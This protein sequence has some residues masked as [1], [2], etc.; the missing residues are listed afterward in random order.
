MERT[1]PG[2]LVVGVDAS[3]AGDAALHHAFTEAVLRGASLRVVV[4]CPPA[5]PRASGDGPLPVPD[6]GT[7]RRALAALVRRHVDDVRPLVP[8]AADVEVDVRAVTGGP[9]EVL[10]GA[11]RDADLLVVGHRGRGARCGEPSGSI[12]LGVVLHASC[13]VT[14]VPAPVPG[15]T[16]FYETSP[17]PLPTGPIARTAP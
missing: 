15:R 2:V 1:G 5:P 4:A 7:V 14:V 10:A 11:A 13:P 12:E 16:A 8:G 6:A 9:V 3:Q 17:G